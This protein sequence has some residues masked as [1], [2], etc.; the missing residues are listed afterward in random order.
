MRL[1]IPA[2]SRMYRG[3]VYYRPPERMRNMEDLT[4][5]ELTRMVLTKEMLGKPVLI[6]HQGMWNVGRIFDFK[7]DMSSSMGKLAVDLVD[8]RL[9]RGLSLSHR[10]LS[11]HGEEVSICLKGKRPDTWIINAS[12]AYV[13]EAPHECIV[14]VVPMSEQSAANVHPIDY[15]KLAATVASTQQQLLAHQQQQLLQAQSQSPQHGFPVPPETVSWMFKEFEQFQRRRA[16]E[17]KKRLEEENKAKSVEQLRKEIV[18]LKTAL[19]NQDIHYSEFGAKKAKADSEPGGGESKGGGG[20]DGRDGA[21]TG[22]SE[23]EDEPGGPG[24]KKR[25]REVEARSMSQGHRKDAHTQDKEHV[26]EVDPVAVILANKGRLDPAQADIIIRKH[27]EDQ[28]RIKRLEGANKKF[29]TNTLRLFGN[30]LKGSVHPDFRQDQDVAKRIE[31]LKLHAIE[32]PETQEFAI[33]CSSFIDDYCRNGA[34]PSSQAQ[35]GTAATKTTGVG[36]GGE[37]APDQTSA[38][39]MSNEELWQILS[40]KWNEQA[41]T[42]STPPISQSVPA[43]QADATTTAQDVPVQASAAQGNAIP[44][45]GA[46]KEKVPVDV[47]PRDT[48]NFIHSALNS[49]HDAGTIIRRNPHDGEIWMRSGPPAW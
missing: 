2:W 4:R 41:G 9:M 48:S 25:G 34:P 5:S 12:N 22:V 17:E 14:P 35:G 15:E 6:E 40:N 32:T 1:G 36:G 45:T 7:L 43:P 39:H 16:D 24:K 31:E 44:A 38:R 18:D 42:Y 28:E 23:E 33:Q 8:K 27:K 13:P 10:F 30:M 3:C 11:R 20:G 47:D 37:S 19:A 46:Q 26:G 49:I 21:T 29:A